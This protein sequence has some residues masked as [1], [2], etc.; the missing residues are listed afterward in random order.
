MFISNPGKAKKLA[1]SLGIIHKTDKWDAA[2]L[3]KCGSI[4][5]DDIA[6]W[7]P[8]D[9]GTRAIKTLIRRLNAL[10]KDKLRESNRLEASLISDADK[11]VIQSTRY[12]ISILDSEINDIQNEIDLLISSNDAMN[13]NRELLLSVPGIGTVMARELVYL[14]SA[15]RFKSAKQ[16]AAYVGLIP[17][18]NEAGVFKGRSSLSKS[19]PSRI[20]SK[21]FLATVCACT[22]NPDIN[23]QKDRL[24]YTGKTKMQELGAAMRTLVQICFGA[25]KNKTRYQPQIV[26]TQY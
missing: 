13:K 1:Q 2:M 3:E 24:I 10:E 9:D 6:L 21:I 18:L 12:L 20:R 14:F 23:A 15:K 22:H 19:G 26:L 8:E 11:R 5:L 7:N 16:V 17:R 4:Q 25:I